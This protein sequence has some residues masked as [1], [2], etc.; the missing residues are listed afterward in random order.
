MGEC[1]F[2]VETEYAI[3]GTRRGESVDLYKIVR[4][5]L[6]RAHATLTGVPD[7]RSSGLFVENGSRFYIDSG[8]HP[9][10]STPECTNPWDAVRYI[11]SGHGQMHRLMR[12]VDGA[13]PELETA[14]YRANVDY[15]GSGATWGCHESFLHRAAP[16]SLPASLIPHLVTRIVYTG[17]GGFNPFSP[18][19]EFTLSP[20][21]AHIEEVI[22]PDA[23]T[24]RGIFHS[25][26]ESLC[27]GYNRLHV[28]CGENLCSHRAMFVKIGATCLVVALIDAG[29]APGCAVELASP[30]DAL[31]VVAAD[32][33]LKR[34][35]KLASG[36]RMTALE[37]QHH[38][39]SMA[40]ENI[41]REFMP[42]WAAEICR[43]WRLLLELL[44]AGN[45]AARTSVDWCMK[46]AMF[47]NHAKSCGLT[48][49]H[50][51]FWNALI[52]RLSCKFHSSGERRPVTPAN[53]LE[54]LNG[55]SVLREPLGAIL[56]R[57]ALVL[58][59][60]AAVLSRRAEFF[61][62]DMRFG[63][64]GPEGLFSRLD[65]AGVL[66]HRVEGIDNIE[67]AMH[68]PP[69]SGR[70]RLRGAVIKRVAQDRQGEWLCTWRQIASKR[71]LRCLDL[72]DPFAAQELWH[73][74]GPD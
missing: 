14:C 2:G 55:N 9:E 43:Q 36:A 51:G 26:N 1:L 69:A 65:A 46:L 59:E 42:P 48:W 50:L 57:R 74:M 68:N 64:L 38:Y 29:F 35:L 21:A 13:I 31:R 73:D 72:S 3:N 40:E 6:N 17:A 47:V 34:P 18:G 60:M 33:T 25:K 23:A 22:S 5:L 63:Q 67:H 61:E 27:N 58:D 11:E 24:G 49:S 66:D 41:G 19:L 16:E 10:I 71:Y 45:E 15:S 30:L 53:A 20:R 62:L 8:N 44:S 70:A 39:L 54:D 37:I 12:E 7:A 4:E 32:T 52:H 28:I 56:R